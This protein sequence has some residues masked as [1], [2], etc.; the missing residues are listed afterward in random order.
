MVVDLSLR[1]IRA[2][3]RM[4]T[5][6]RKVLC[7][8]NYSRPWQNYR[9]EEGMETHATTNRYIGA[10]AL[11]A[12]VI[13]GAF[14]VVAS[15]GD[16]EAMALGVLAALILV[17]PFAMLAPGIPRDRTYRSAMAVAFAAAFILFWMIGAVGL[18]ATGDEH[19][20][21]LIY[22]AVPVVGI[23]GAIAAH[24]RP[25]GMAW[26]LLAT[27]ITQLLVPLIIVI[28][29]LNL[30]PIAMTE[31]TAFTLIVNSPFAALYVVSAWLFRKA[32]RE[33]H[34]TGGREAHMDNPWDR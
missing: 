8:L 26:A 13:I 9:A 20:N 23:S 5:L 33:H 7:K 6:Y 2:A 27:A 1:K 19:P 24:F 11:A 12:A 21:D 34:R 29:G 25:L 32:A 4:L 15:E 22:I 31:L 3:L 18:M 14:P 10:F 28:A 30:V 16:P 17:F